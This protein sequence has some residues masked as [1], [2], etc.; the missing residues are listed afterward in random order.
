M[1][2]GNLQSGTGQLQEAYE[3]LQEAWLRTREYWSDQNAEAFE[4]TYLKVIAEEINQALPAISQ[5][6]QT[7]GRAARD[8]EE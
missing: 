4:E 3:K 2:T 6:S 5:M 8:C 7:I 1:R